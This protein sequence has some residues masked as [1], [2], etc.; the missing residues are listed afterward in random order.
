[1][2]QSNCLWTLNGA[3]IP[4]YYGNSLT[5]HGMVPLLTYLSGHDLN[6]ILIMEIWLRYAVVNTIMF[7]SFHQ[8]CAFITFLFWKIE[9]QMIRD[10]KLTAK[11]PSLLACLWLPIHGVDLG[12]VNFICKHLEILIFIKRLAFF[13]HIFRR[14]SAIKGLHI[15]YYIGLASTW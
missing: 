10:A 9:S 13:I 3:I 2:C 8:F 15:K 4:Q 11:L 5:Y 12:K 7:H 14:P 6:W 1:M